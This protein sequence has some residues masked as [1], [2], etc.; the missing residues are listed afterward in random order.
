MLKTR[1]AVAKTVQER[2]VSAE[3]LNDQSIVA[4][5]ELMIAL[6]SG[7]EQINAAAAVG[8]QAF[9]HVASALAASGET[10]RRLVAAHAE[11]ARVKETIGLGA[12]AL[13]GGANKDPDQFFTSGQLALVEGGRAA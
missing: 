7:T 3:R 12:I 6:L 11:L 2:L 13:G 1:I 9:E 5:A 8:Q 10:R 4:S